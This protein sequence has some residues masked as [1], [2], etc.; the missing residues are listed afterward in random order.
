MVV[1]LL[2][3]EL[4]QFN[5]NCISGYTRWFAQLRHNLLGHDGM[6]VPVCRGKNV[7]SNRI[8]PSTTSAPPKVAKE[9]IPLPPDKTVCPL[10]LQKRT[11]PSVMAVSGFVFCYTCIFKYAN[12]VRIYFGNVFIIDF[13]AVFAP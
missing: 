10:C 8:P 5:P 2:G 7:S 9:G 6:V 3:S 4:N 12:Q 1:L 11:N 13:N